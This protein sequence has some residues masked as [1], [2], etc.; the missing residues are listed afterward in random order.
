MIIAYLISNPQFNI[1]NISYITSQWT[2]LEPSFLGFFDELWDEHRLLKVAIKC[3][4][5]SSTLSSGNFLKQLALLD[6]C[7][8]SA[9]V[10]SAQKQKH[11]VILRMS[12]VFVRCKGVIFGMNF[13]GPVTFQFI[14]YWIS[15]RFTGANKRSLCVLTDGVMFV[16]SPLF[17]S[18]K[19]T[20]TQNTSFFFLPLEKKLLL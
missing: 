20:P 19:R 15:V 3:F 8:Q 12:R 5:P 14:F 6:P 17:L 10:Q 4:C 13:N 7:L 18:F 1:W 11:L 2:F 9:L 16:D